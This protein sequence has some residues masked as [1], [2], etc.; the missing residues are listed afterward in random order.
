MKICRWWLYN[1]WS[2]MTFWIVLSWKKT[3]RLYTWLFSKPSSTYSFRHTS[4]S[5]IAK[6]LVREPF[7]I[8][9]R[10]WQLELGFSPI[11][12]RYERNMDLFSLTSETLRRRFLSGPL[13]VVCIGMLNSSSQSRFFRHLQ[14]TSTHQKRRHCGPG[15]SLKILDH[16]LCTNQRSLKKSEMVIRHWSRR[17]IGE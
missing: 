6:L 8:A 5:S 9:Y 7:S 17:M 4:K 12:R 1:S 3:I 2:C 14:M 15:M 13:C 16:T 10:T 11:K